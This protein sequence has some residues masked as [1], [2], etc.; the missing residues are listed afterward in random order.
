MIKILIADD[1]PVVREGMK[2]IIANE[3]DL[4]VGGEAVT[5]QEVLEQVQREP[6]DLVVLDLNMPG[7]GGFEVL[8]DLR[9]DFP[10]VRVLIISLHPAR[11]VGPR[12][13]KA[14]ADGYLNKDSAPE[15]LVS[16]IRTISSG[17]KF[18]TPEIAEM[19]A[20]DADTGRGKTFLHENL[21]D[22]EYQ[23]LCMIA[24]GKSIK[25]I[26][27]DLSLSPKT[28]RTFRERIFQKL[29]LHNDVELTHYA[30]THNL[31][32]HPSS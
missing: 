6:W 17:R 12:I 14:G 5:G 9:R 21:S 32:D 8:K 23:V 26:G 20:T 15:E 13:Y 19:L 30:L 31:I 1:H 2:R 25:A 27:K 28:I 7:K 29:N 10:R 18:V 4:M 11:E 16:A 3:L 24:Q 22:R